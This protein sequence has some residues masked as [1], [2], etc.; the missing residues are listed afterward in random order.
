M[1]RFY[2]FTKFRSTFFF[3]T[4]HSRLK[5]ISIYRAIVLIKLK[6]Q[7]GFHLT[8]EIQCKSIVSTGDESYLTLEKKL[9]MNFHELHAFPVEGALNITGLSHDLI[10]HSHLMFCSLLEV[11]RGGGTMT[12]RTRNDISLLVKKKSLFYCSQRNNTLCILKILRILGQSCSERASC[13][14]SDTYNMVY[15]FFFF[16]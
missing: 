7:G 9:F 15:H 13:V 2:K 12:L 16:Y 4:Y 11:G 8:S 14:Q 1:V 6:R 3:N 5:Q 10:E